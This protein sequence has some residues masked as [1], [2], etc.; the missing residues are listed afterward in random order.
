MNALTLMGILLGTALIIDAS[1]GSHIHFTVI[2]DE[3]RGVNAWFTEFYSGGH[4]YTEAMT[5]NGQEVANAKLSDVSQIPDPII[6]S[7]VKAWGLRNLGKNV[8][9]PNGGRLKG[10]AVPESVRVLPSMFVN[11]GRMGI[12]VADTI[13]SQTKEP[14]GLSVLWA[15]ME[16]DA[17]GDWSVSAEESPATQMLY[18]AV[19]L[20][21]IQFIPGLP[22]WHQA[23]DGAIYLGLDSEGTKFT[24]ADFPTSPIRISISGGHDLNIPIGKPV[25]EAL[26]DKPDQAEKFRKF[27]NTIYRQQRGSSL[28]LENGSAIWISDLDGLDQKIGTDESHPNYLHFK[29]N[30]AEPEIVYL[31]TASPYAVVGVRFGKTEERILWSYLVTDESGDPKFVIKE[32]VIAQDPAL[33]LLSSILDA[34]KDA[35]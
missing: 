29:T 24:R 9:A 12:L 35:W 26:N 15:F 20:D 1:E 2:G 10:V 21:P 11:G 7:L 31:L 14:F 19:L 27:L 3:K 34:A 32:N 30:A 16:R 4:N 5:G 22:S 17:N 18:Q 8:L 25:Y 33:S 28:D 6:A 23:P 13:D